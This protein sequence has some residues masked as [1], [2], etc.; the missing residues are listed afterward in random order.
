MI[1]TIRVSAFTLCPQDNR[2]IPSW[3]KWVY[4]YIPFVL[5]LHR[6]LIYVKVRLSHYVPEYLTPTP[7]T[8]ASLVFLVFTPSPRGIL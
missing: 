4:A 6:F 5:L 3:L 2:V 8:L 7:K 1:L